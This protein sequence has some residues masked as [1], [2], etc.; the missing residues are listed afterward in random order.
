MQS[1]IRFFVA[2]K[3]LIFRDG[4]FL[5]IQRSDG[6]RDG[7]GLWELPGGRLE[8]GE[9]PEEALRREI[10]EET[11]LSAS[12]LSITHSWTFIRKE[13][14]QT[15]GMT[16]LCRGGAEAVRLSP[17]HEG[18]AWIDRSEMDRYPMDPMVRSAL[19]ALDWERI[20][21]EVEQ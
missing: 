19:L 8:F 12:P 11:G 2:V 5:I 18:H 14:F 3:G 20:V 1:E 6:A 7:K 13:R 15:V 9:A 21:R 16:F 4:R 17:E 10:R